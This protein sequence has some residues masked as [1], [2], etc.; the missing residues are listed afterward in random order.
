[1]TKKTKIGC[2]TIGQT[3]RA[4]VLEELVPIFGSEVQILEAG[5]LDGLTK[6][7]IEAEFQPAPG[8]YVLVSRLRTGE[9]VTIGESHILDRLQSC[10]EELEDQVDFILL[11][12]TGVFKKR[13][14]VKV[15]VYYPN[16]II[17]GLLPVLVKGQ[18]LLILNPS[19][20]QISQS[21][22]R[23]EG[24]IDGVRVLAASPYDLTRGMQNAVQQIRES[25]AQMVFLD[26][27]GYT[28]AMKREI[29]SQTGLPVLLSKTLVARAL[30]EQL[31][32]GGFP[33]QGKIGAM[34]T[35]LR[36]LFDDLNEGVIISDETGRVIVYNKAMEKMENKSAEKMIGKFIWEAYG[37][38]DRNASEHF[39]VLE[40][41]RELVNIY[42]AHV[43]VNGVPQYTNYSTYPIKDEEEI[44]GVLSICKNEKELHS[45]LMDTIESRRKHNVNYDIATGRT[46]SENGTSYS[47]SDFVGE[48]EEISR[49]IKEA[50]NIA[51]LDNSILIVGETGTGKEVLAQSIHNYG[52]RSVEPFIGVNCGAIPEN[53]IESILFGTVK[54]AFT[55][56]VDHPGLLEEAGTGTLFLDEINSMPVLTQSKLLRV[57]QE[58]RVNRVGDNKSYEIKCRFI[59]AMNEQPH[60]AIQGGSF[61]EDLYYRLAG[62]N[63]YIPALRER[64]SD[65]DLL[66][67]SFLKRYAPLMGKN[68]IDIDDRLRSIL[69][70]YPWP[71]NI[72]ELENLVENMLVSADANE[73]VLGVEHIPAYLEKRILGPNPYL[74]YEESEDSLPSTLASIEREIIRKSLEKNDYN[75]TK[76]A[77][78]LGIIRQSLMYRI[79]K[80]EIEPRDN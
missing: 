71:G 74:D 22:K 76:T 59:S 10:A 24:K 55:G 18:R 53:L 9:E 36:A 60:D 42:S 72:R 73:R 6:E 51:W 15:P 69:Q 20:E 80:L 34:S 3:P 33:Q 49:L 66:I 62:F 7:R 41:G 32:G 77:K 19:T 57:L 79:K 50:Q 44:I 39:Q 68:I 29:Q 43:S 46:Y 75:Y 25:D 70:N 8:E 54:G 16:E 12:C 37:Y 65:I 58:K 78:E 5:A 23:W 56:A 40:T 30:S 4:D 48:S 13:L 17:D 14:Q 45:L 47:F 38:N 63:L 52:K 64:K 61:R 31:Q 11:L 26:C 2:I 1:M 21:L 28:E 27:I 35:T 67:L